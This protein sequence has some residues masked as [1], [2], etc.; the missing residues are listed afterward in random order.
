[1]TL[2]HAGVRNDDLLTAVRIER[3]ESAAVIT[4]GAWHRGWANRGHGR[5]HG[6]PQ[7]G[8]TAHSIHSKCIH[9]D[10]GKRGAG[11]YPRA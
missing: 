5:M 10:G 7:A 8:D 1:M 9:G 6:E 2:P 11:R 3:D 4:A